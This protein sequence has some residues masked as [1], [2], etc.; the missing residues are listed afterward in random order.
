[1]GFAV[2]GLAWVN[3]SY[4]AAAVEAVAFQASHQVIEQ[5]ACLEAYH[6]RHIT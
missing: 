3:R 6:I 4:I 1:M 2:V 5:E